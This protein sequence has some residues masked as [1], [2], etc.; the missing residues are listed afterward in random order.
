MSKNGAIS[1]NSRSYE[2]K[3]LLFGCIL[4]LSGFLP[5]TIYRYLNGDYLV[6]FMESLLAIAILGIFAYVWRAQKIA[7]ASILMC[8]LSLTV[9]VSVIHI[10]GPTLV[11]W[12]YPATLI[13]FCI[14]KPR[15]AAIL[16][17]TA[18]LLMLPALYPK[19][20]VHEVM[21]IYTTMALLSLFGYTF[22]LATRQQRKQLSQLAAR[23]ALTGAY[24]RRSLDENMRISISKLRRQ[25][26]RKS[27]LLI[28]D[29]DH[30]K[31][32]N[33]NYGHSSGD[34]ILI[35]IADLIRSSIR[36]SDRLYRYGGEEFVII[37]DCAGQDE[38]ASLAE[39]IRNRVETSNLFDKRGVTIS[40]GV[41]ELAI[42]YSAEHWLA[43]ADGAL[44]KA[45][46]NGRN[47][48]CLADT[49]TLGAAA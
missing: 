37:A 28:L 47:Q 7:I 3:I 23:D 20:V 27:T 6:A 1:L 43:L 25:P 34:Q 38:A 24:N 16:N 39:N 29:L 46:R 32:I 13:C 2:E 33:D 10:K 30:F 40:V 36:L 49:E 45:K 26:Q 42:E 5:F 22:T 19:L 41:A 14:L 44:Y 18:A 17:L 21:V 15:T 31:E 48:V 11:Y 4:G 35:K 12:A 8:C 9:T